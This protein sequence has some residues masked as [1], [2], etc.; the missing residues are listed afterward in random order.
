M[1][2]NHKQELRKR[3]TYDEMLKQA[4]TSKMKTTV[5]LKKYKKYMLLNNFDFDKMDLMN[6][7]NKER[8]MNAQ[9][10]MADASPEAREL[11]DKAT[12]TLNKENK[13][14]QTDLPNDKATQTYN[15]D[16]MTKILGGSSKS[17][18]S[19]LITKAEAEAIA[20][21]YDPDLYDDD[22]DDDDDK[23]D[24][25][26]DKYRKKL[27]ILMRI[28]EFMMRSGFSIGQ[29]V[30][31]LTYHTT[32]TTIQ[33]SELLVNLTMNSLVTSYDIATAIMNWLNTNVSEEVELNTSPPI[34]VNSSPPVE[35]SSI[36]DDEQSSSSPI[37]VNSS[38]THTVNSSSSEEN[39]NYEIAPPT[40]IPIPTDAESE[41]E[42]KDKDKNKEK[43]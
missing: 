36:A 11:R 3:P 13:A 40:E 31:H 16:D 22:D 39:S 24:D 34:S 42:D 27:F 33:G 8:Y 28:I 32:L 38:S 6:Y 37:T 15:F 20:F 2:N 26:I 17:F 41:N 18:K 43:Q 4:I 7:K 29:I 5:I 9:V 12:Q 25:D 30:A 21:T 19:K 1:I 10:M 35:L 14:T 23:N